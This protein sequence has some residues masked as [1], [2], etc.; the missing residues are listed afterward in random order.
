MTDAEVSPITRAS[1]TAWKLAAPPTAVRFAQRLLTLRS[2][3]AAR[4]STALP[5]AVCDTQ[6]E[7]SYSPL[8]AA[9]I[10]AVLGRGS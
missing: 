4:H 6:L 2:F 10:D 8:G 3:I 7:L 5:T 1:W 9:W